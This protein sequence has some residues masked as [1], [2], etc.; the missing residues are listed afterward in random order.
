MLAHHASGVFVRFGHGLV[1]QFGIGNKPKI[2]SPLPCGK[3]SAFV[4]NDL[5]QPAT[6]SIP[7]P[8]IL[9]TAVGA[10]ESKL[11][12][13][14][15]IRPRSHHSN[16]ESGARVPVPLEQLTERFNVTA[17]DLSDQLGVGPILHRGMTM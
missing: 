4:D 5:I 14:I 1:Y 17:N 16:G 8:A 9:Q 2:A 13:V 10:H 3:R 6:K 7:V 11:Q 12:H 15:R